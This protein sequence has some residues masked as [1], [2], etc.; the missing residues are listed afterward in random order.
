MPGSEEERQYWGRLALT[1]DAE[2]R[3][4]VG[5]A[6]E[7][8]IRSWLEQQFPAGDE[9]LELDC[10]T[11]IFSAMIAD[12]VR[13][14][15]ATDFSPEM[16]E[17]ATRRLGGY[18]NVRLQRGDAYHTSFTDDSFGAVLAVGLLHHVQTPAA[19]VRECHPILT[20]GGKLAVVDCT[21]HGTCLR[22]LVLMGLRYLRYRGRPP[23]TG[24]SF[25]SPD[26]LA[27]LITDAGLAVQETTVIDQRRPR[28]RLTGIRATN[29]G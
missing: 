15:T 6:F 18:D 23:K 9:V 4:C 3:G 7:N 27:A 29:A 5:E 2:Y 8:G 16:L 25:S 26:E 14:L 19:V 11:G 13:H 17:Q 1:Y 20:P 10:G 21:E 12:R 22:S 28:M 24:H